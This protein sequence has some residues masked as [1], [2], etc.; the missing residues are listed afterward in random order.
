MDSQL[1][2]FSPSG[3]AGAL[4]AM[5]DAIALA[6][7]IAALEPKDMNDLNLMFKEY[8]AERYPIAKDTFVRSQ[9]F[10]KVLGKVTH[11]V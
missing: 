8:H 6:N 5:H 9:M 10:N 1:F 3:A 2:Q 4:T 11:H 7:W